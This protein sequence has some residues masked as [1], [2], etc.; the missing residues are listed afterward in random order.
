M[1]NKNL[2]RVSIITATYKA[3]SKEQKTFFYEMFRS[4]HEQDYPNI[5]HIIIDGGSKDGSVDFIKQ[6]INKYAKKQVVFVSE[7]DKGIN[8][9]TNKGYLKSTGDYIT[10]MCDDD[11]YVRPDAISNL[12]EKLKAENLDFVCADTWWLDAKSW[13][14]DSKSFIYRHPFLINALL[15]KRDLISSPP[16]Y[17]DEE[18]PLCADYDLFLRFLTND[19]IKGGEIKEVYT[20]LRPGGVSQNS[21]QIYFDD[22]LHIYRKY[23]KSKFFNDAELLRMH[24]Q[25]SGLIT[26][27]KLLLFCK[28]KEIKESVKHLYTPKYIKNYIVRR[29]EFFCFM[30]FITNWWKVKAPKQTI[31]KDYSRTKS[32]KWIETFYQELY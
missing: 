30:K 28:N 32:R 19:K 2:P 22:T 16:Y 4:I 23:F 26:Y 3:T 17:L 31:D 7:K 8:N 21:T 20:V 18:Y 24:F 14:N 6:I 13:G 29:L 15:F 9:A 5:E 11:F 1:D 12:V 10:L 25:N 27:L